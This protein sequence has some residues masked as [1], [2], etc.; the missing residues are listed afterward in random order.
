MSHRRPRLAVVNTHPIQ[1]HAP[2][3]RALARRSEVDFQV[4]YC[5]EA[6]PQDQAGAGFGVAFRWDVS[7]LD[8][9]AYEFLPNASPKPGVDFW[10]LNNPD[11]PKRILR[12]E[13]DAVVLDGWHYRS[14][15][16]AM[17][18]CW[19]S[20]TAVLARGDSHLKSLRHPVKA[21]VKWPF[22]RFF[23]P[24]LSACLAVGT[25]SREYFQHYGAHPRRIFEV[26]HTVDSERIAREASA[27]MNRRGE[28]RERWNLGADDIVLILP[29]KLIPVKYPLDFVRA[30]A[31]ARQMGAPVTGLIVGD[32]PLRA[33]CEAEVQTSGAPVRFTGFLNQTEIV[34]AYVAADALVSNGRE[35]WGLVVNEAMECGRPCF[36]SDQIGSSADLIEEG[37]T[38]ATFACGDV[39]QFAAVLKKYADRRTLSAMGENARQKIRA[40]T[41]EAAAERLI[42]AV[43]SCVEG[44]KKNAA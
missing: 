22:Y 30:I 18:A 4:L 39:E 15:W 17:Q 36:L 31:R 25:W 26:P 29:G 34:E 43:L 23:I 1:Y 5:H 20:G 32:G 41:P 27:A 2:W 40:Y 13:F 38:G 10:G 33:A 14:A 6:T 16:Q 21:G 19:R 7:L 12:G 35:T 28:I 8:G 9:Y 3:F 42:Q 37:K 11:L 24:R 44:R